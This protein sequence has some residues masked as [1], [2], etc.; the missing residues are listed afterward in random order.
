MG[1]WSESL[2]DELAARIGGNPDRAV[3]LDLLGRTGREIDAMAGRSFPPVQRSTSVF[4]PNGLPLVDIPDAHVGSLESAGVWAVPDPVNP[5][6]AAVLQLV[7]LD[8]SR[9][10]A[11]DLPTADALWNAGRAI[12]AVAR[13]GGLSVDYVIRWLN[14]SF[15]TQQLNALW[16]RIMDPA[17][18]FHVPV[19]GAELGGW[20]MQISR[21]LIWVTGET[22]NEGRLAELLFDTPTAEGMLPIAAVEPILIVA[23]MT[24][25]P[26]NWAFIA[27]VWA[28]PVT[29]QVDRRWTAIAKA[30]H[31]SGIPTITVDSESTLDEV[32]C[33]LLLKAYWHRYF[34]G[35]GPTL[36]NAL[37][38]AYPRQVDYIRRNTHAADSTAAAALLLE[39]LVQPGF[40]PGLGAEATR[41]YVRRKANITVLEYRK[42]ESPDRYPWTQAGISERHYYKLLPV[43]AEK[44]DGRYVIDDYADL[45]RRIIGHLDR[46][47][48][49]RG[50]RA[51]LIE[52]LVSRGFTEPAARKW[53]QRHPREAAATARPRGARPEPAE[54]GPATSPPTRCPR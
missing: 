48:R 2:V 51:V 34:D 23:P 30:I 16:R 52:L 45:V 17:V 4:E 42:T 31:G 13:E 28:K 3:L 33:Q 50:D 5:T 26:M 27:R 49:D 36:A 47:A 43:F 21:R 20:W 29:R 53:L 19:F 38:R 25:Q 54:P 24:Q 44:I 32:A 39:Q 37:A 7:P 46:Q 40:D 11:T 9:P 10:S 8:D 12:A 22:V 15:D 6:M 14:A 18:R 35:T 1:H 41:R